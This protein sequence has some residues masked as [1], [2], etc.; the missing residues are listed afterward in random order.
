M[1]GLVS[2]IMPAYNAENAIAQSIASVVQQSYL[3][4]ELLI[5]DDASTDRTVPVAQ[6]LS[7]N[8]SRIRIISLAQNGGVANARNVAMAQ[9]KG[10]YI[11]FLD[12]DDFWLPEK[13]ESQIRFM[14]E[15]QI[16][17]S[18]TAF[19]RFGTDRPPG[20]LIRAPQYVTYSDLLKDNVI[21]CLTVVIDRQIVPSSFMPQVK[22][23]DLACW[24]QILKSGM[25]AY[26]LQQDLAR[27][28]VSSNSVSGNKQRSAVWRWRI[29][30]EV[31]KL[32]VARAAW[33]FAHYSLRAVYKHL[34]PL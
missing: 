32:S 4:W 13:L 16:G 34:R 9:A 12:S 15:R 26:G 22:H 23:E 27:Y 2:V 21:G 1:A 33:C 10:Q 20:S 14:T 7:A 18:F 19:R 17:F 31:E 8:D 3:N 11:A 25:C 30:R 29:Y 6:A 28:R 5:V 24:L